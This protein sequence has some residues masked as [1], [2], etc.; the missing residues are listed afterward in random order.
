MFN[1][2]LRAFDETVRA[3]SIRKASE[4]LGVAPSSVSRHIALLEHEMGTALF[5]R[6]AGGVDLTHAGTLVAE[7]ARSILMDYD[8]LRTDLDDLRGAQRRLIRLALVE[9]VASSGPIEAIATFHAQHPT[10]AFDLRLLPAPRVIEVVRQG[11]FDIG[12]AFCVQPEAEIVVLETVTEPIVVAVK[13]DHPLASAAGISLEQ[14]AETPL[15]LPDPEFGV[16]RILDQAAAARGFRFAPVL[17]SNSFETLRDFARAGLG[18]AVLPMRAVVRRGDSAPLTAAPLSGAEF[19]NST[20]ELVALRKRR[21]PRIVRLF[22]DKLLIAIR[23]E[24]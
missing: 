6:R 10:V 8:T 23:A 4:A 22:V 9:S 20:I 21:L 13:R 14:L 18:A 2:S 15:A 16:R 19:R 12:L 24:M 5:V 3:G 1:A 11:L 7:Y 17:T